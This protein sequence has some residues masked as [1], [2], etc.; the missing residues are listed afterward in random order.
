MSK[1]IT[2][3]FDKASSIVSL[4]K[5]DRTCANQ[6]AEGFG[7]SVGMF[8]AMLTNEIDRMPNNGTISITISKEL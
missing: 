8:T 6:L 7:E 3:Y 1:T 2:Y 5:H 4:H